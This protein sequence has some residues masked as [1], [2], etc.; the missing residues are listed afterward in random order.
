MPATPWFTTKKSVN[1]FCL[2]NTLTLFDALIAGPSLKLP[3]A[4][5]VVHALRCIHESGRVLEMGRQ[6]GMQ[7]RVPTSCIALVQLQIREL[8][9]PGPRLITKQKLGSIGPLSVRGGGL[10]IW[11]G[12]VWY[13]SSG[14]E[15]IRK[16]WHHWRPVNLGFHFYLTQFIH[17]PWVVWKLV[18]CALKYSFSP[19]EYEIQEMA[20][21]PSY[22]GLWDDI[23]DSINQL[24]VFKHVKVQVGLYPSHKVYLMN[25]L[26]DGRR[27]TRSQAHFERIFALVKKEENPLW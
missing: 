10:Q 15:G 8:H 5:L 1:K 26:H 24:Q 18:F 23:V 13:V 7:P 20:L 4:C 6:E 14:P 17:C 2:S 22:K 3:V 11:S 9:L 27:P 12:F 21:T 16:P 25:T 19:L